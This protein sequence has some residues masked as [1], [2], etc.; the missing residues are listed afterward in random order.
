MAKGTTTKTDKKVGTTKKVETKTGTTKKVVE[1]PVNTT[2][3]EKNDKAAKT[4]KVTSDKNVT[5]GSANKTVTDNQKKTGGVGAGSLISNS[6]AVSM[7]TTT[8]DQFTLNKFFRNGFNNLVSRISRVFDGDDKP[9]VVA[10]NREKRGNRNFQQNL[11]IAFKYSAPISTT[12]ILGLPPKFTSLADIR[13]FNYKSIDKEGRTSIEHSDLEEYINSDGYEAYFFSEPYQGQK[14]I[15]VYLKYASLVF[16]EIGRPIFFNGISSELKEAILSQQIAQDDGVKLAATEVAGDTASAAT[17]ITFAPAGVEYAFGVKLLTDAIAQFMDIDG[18]SVNEF[19]NAHNFDAAGRGSLWRHDLQTGVGNVNQYRD[20]FELP[21]SYDNAV[22][23]DKD[24]KKITDHIEVKDLAT[25]KK[26]NAIKGLMNSNGNS[27]PV[28]GHGR[29]DV[30]D[31]TND[32][33]AE[34]KGS[35]ICVYSDGGIEAPL[36]ITHETGPS[37]ILAPLVNNA[38]IDS[39]AE[40]SFFAKDFDPQRTTASEGKYDEQNKFMA[41]LKKILHISSVGAKL[42]APEVWKGSGMERSFEV[43]MVLQ[44]TSPTK[45][46]IFREIMVPYMHI[47]EMVS[48]RN[49]THVST[50]MANRLGALAPPYVL[51]MYCRGAAT[52]N[53]GLPTSI[54]VNKNPK[55]L[56]I[57]GLPTRLEITMTIKDLYGIFGVP[58]YKDT[59]TRL[60]IVQCMGLTEYLSALT[61]VVMSQ[62]KV[63]DMY[64]I[65]LKDTSMKSYGFNVVKKFAARIQTSLFQGYNERVSGAIGSIV[66]RV[67]K[68]F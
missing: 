34:I 59:N 29:Y 36:N 42:V 9:G 55:D 68:I 16:F 15:E 27:F 30:N 6:G 56:T 21:K 11:R 4:A 64:L 67:N 14:W 49:I 61:G 60:A 40:I 53:L 1:Q 51:R 25:E 18:E 31:Y 22:R 23:K 8:D 57:D 12:G 7:S 13:L 63:R 20:Y 62:E 2:S 28:G 58:I 32:I 46:C 44:A 41:F 50:A 10:Q 52:V 33:Y 47:L 24:G 65:S 37:T 3:T 5:Q 48:P 38:V 54:T 66:G 39:M 35:T 26:Y 19:L 45:V 17:L 43:K